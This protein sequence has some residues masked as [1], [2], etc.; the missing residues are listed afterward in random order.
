MY[1]MAGVELTRKDGKYIGVAGGT[2]FFV[3]M[4]IAYRKKLLPLAK[5]Q[6]D[7]GFKG[8]AALSA[9]KDTTEDEKKI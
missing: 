3:A 5:S 7:M 9:P 6:Q 1:K 2:Y 4:M 8:S